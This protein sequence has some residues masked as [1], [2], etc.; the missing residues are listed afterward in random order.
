MKIATWNINSIKVRLPAVIQYLEETAPDVLALQETKALDENFPEKEIKKL[1]YSCI[2]TGQ[3]TYNGVAI[4][5]KTKPL[6]VELNPV[7]TSENEKRSIA[8]T[9][10][11]VKVLNLYVVNGQDIGTPKYQYKLRWLKALLEYASSIT[12]EHTKIEILGDFNIAP[13]DNDV[14]DIEATKEQILCSSEER[15]ILKELKKIGLNDLFLNFNYPPKTFS[16][17]DYRGGAFH[18]NIGYR[19][20]LILGSKLIEGT[21]SKV[22][23]DK[24]TRHKSWCKKEPRTSDHAP[25]VAVFEE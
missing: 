18:R 12:K 5:S 19:I 10:S 21:C 15:N 20:D 14:F 6:E 8:A 25:V 22:Y 7:T 23:I 4:I 13:T 1:G 9:Y 2:F 16:W 24:E 3:K 11:G 17:W